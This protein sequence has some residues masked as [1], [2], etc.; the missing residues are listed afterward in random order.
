M[1]NPDFSWVKSSYSSS[2]NCVEV[3]TVG[4]VL[5]RDSKNDSGVV[6]QFAPEVWRRFADRVKRS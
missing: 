6:L 1:K 2:G 5:L 4:S 3:A